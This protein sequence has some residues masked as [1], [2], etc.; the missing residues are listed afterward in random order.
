MLD[1][2]WAREVAAWF[3]AAHSDPLDPVVIGLHQLHVWAI[4]LGAP[5]V[6]AG[7]LVGAAL[8]RAYAQRARAAQGANVAERDRAGAAAISPAS[9]VPA[10]QG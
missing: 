7:I 9:A 5:L 6:L 1:E 8:D 2:A 10:K 3:A 4:F